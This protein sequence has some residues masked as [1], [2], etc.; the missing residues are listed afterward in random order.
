ML[1]TRAG[2]DETPDLMKLRDS[3][4]NFVLCFRCGKS[5]LNRRE[6]ISCDF[7]TL[8]WHLDCLDPPLANPPR[9]GSGGKPRHS[10]MCPNHVDHELAALDASATS[11]A[12]LHF[13]SGN[14]RTHK[15]RRPKNAKIVDT[16]LRRGFINNGLIE[17]ENEPSDEEEFHE[18]EQLGVVY[19]LPERGIKLDFIDRVKRYLLSRVYSTGLC[20]D[21]MEQVLA[22]KPTHYTACVPCRHIPRRRAE[23]PRYSPSS[24]GNERLSEASIC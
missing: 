12:R 15:V 7:C 16:G 9:K 4:G 1:R 2:Y 11:S 6:I 13:H 20:T 22:G 3:K 23:A 14:G 18:R 21:S 17:I 19:R 8:Q 5:S 24:S 10:W